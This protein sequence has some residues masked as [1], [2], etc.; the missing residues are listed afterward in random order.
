MYEIT[1]DTEI[2]KKCGSCAKACPVDV[3]QQTAKATYPLI[4]DDRLEY[5]IGCGQCAAIC[6]QGAIRHSEYP[7]VHNATNPI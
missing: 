4:E 6:P 7:D 1:I 5:C 3:I 2:C